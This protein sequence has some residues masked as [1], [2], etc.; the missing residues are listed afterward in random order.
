[1]CEAEALVD[2]LLQHCLVWSVVVFA[3][4]SLINS[5]LALHTMF[6][7]LTPH[8]CWSRLALVQPL[9]MATMGWMQSNVGDAV[10]E[11]LWP[12]VANWPLHLQQDLKEHAEELAQRAKDQDDL[13]K[14]IRAGR[15]AGK[16]GKQ[17][18]HLVK[19]H[20]KQLNIKIKN[21]NTKLKQ[22][23]KFQKEMSAHHA[24]KIKAVKA[25][26]YQYLTRLTKEKHKLLDDQQALMMV[27]K[28]LK[29]LTA[30]QPQP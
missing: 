20:V 13:K 5:A 16:N 15:A 2:S 19:Q 4:V 21:I 23:L 28:K 7:S 14:A 6:I 25:F 11:L 3:S 17:Q 12:W 26:A 24:K 22:H 18:H 8:L 1:M 10:E 27:K 9:A 29:D 30:K